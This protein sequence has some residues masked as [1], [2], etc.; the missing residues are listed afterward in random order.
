MNRSPLV[1]Q[2][3]QVA[4]KWLSDPE[5]KLFMQSRNTACNTFLVTSTIFQSAHNNIKG[6]VYPTKKWTVLLGLELP[7]S[8]PFIIAPK[9]RVFY[10]KNWPD[11]TA[12]PWVGQNRKLRLVKIL[13]IQFLNSKKNIRSKIKNVI[14][15]TCSQ[16]C[17]LSN[18]P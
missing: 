10:K 6:I 18:K 11:P 5:G 4:Q 9:L 13:N 7:Y 14:R 15:G 12:Q 8:Y 2:S 16:P 17:S 1:M 3:I